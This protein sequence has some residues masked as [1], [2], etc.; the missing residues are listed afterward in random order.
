V[1]EVN[2]SLKEGTLFRFWIAALVAVLA[3]VVVVPLELSAGDSAMLSYDFDEGHNQDY[4]VK[5]TQETFFG[6]YS[7]SVFADMEITEKCAGITEDGKF[8]MEVIF[9]KVESSMMW[10]DKMQ[11]SKMGDALMGQSVAFVVDGHGEVDDLKALGYIESWRQ[12]EGSIKQLVKGFYPYLPGKEISKG[13]N[14]EDSK[15][16]DEE[17]MHVT[18]NAVYT[19][20]EMKE[21]KG[22]N[23]ARVES[24]VETGIGGVSS[25]PMG[26]YK[27]EGSGE[28]GGEFFFDPA[29]GIIVKIKEKIEIKMDMTPVSGGD[30]VET[31]VSF[32]IERELL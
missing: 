13:E 7:S 19:F 24:E 20:K 27:A 26:E 23:C 22:R 21:E 15:E 30:A 12:F 9:N 28:G 2:M 17:G 1:K 3:V 10:M 5:F 32:Q 6:T 31:T 4:K 8:R 18:S 11:D 14:W 16:T 29:E 25:T